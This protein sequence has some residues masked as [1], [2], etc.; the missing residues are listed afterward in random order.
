MKQVYQKTI[1]VRLKFTLL[2]SCLFFVGIQSALPQKTKLQNGFVNS[3][4]INPYYTSPTWKLWD[5]DSSSVT[6]AA[7]IAPGQVGTMSAV[8]S[9]N[10]LYPDDIITPGKFLEYRTTDWSGRKYA[11]FWD[12]VYFSV[13]GNN[14]TPQTPHSFINGGYLSSK[15]NAIWFG[16]GKWLMGYKGNIQNNPGIDQ[17]GVNW[18]SQSTT[19]MGENIAAGNWNWAGSPYGPNSIEKDWYF[20]NCLRAGPAHDSYFEN[21]FYQMYDLYQAIVPCYYNSLGSSGT[22]TNALLKMLVAGGYLPKD[23]KPELKRNGIYTATMLYIWKACL[24][25]DVPYDNELKHRVCYTSVGDYVVAVNTSNRAFHLYYDSLHM[26]AMVNMA[27]NMTVAPPVALLNKISVT[28]GTE[29]Y[30]NKTAALIHQA[31]GETIIIQ[32]STADCYDIAGT[33]LTKRWKLLNGNPGT[34]ITGSGDT[35]TITVPYDPKLP[36]GR[37]TIMLVANNGSYDSNPAFINVYRPDGAVNLRPLISGATDTVVFPGGTVTLNLVGTD[38]EGYPCTFYKRTEDPGIISGNQ[39]IWSNATKTGTKADYQVAILCSDGTTGTNS[40]FVNI[41]VAD[42]IAK[43]SADVISGSTPITVNFSSLGSADSQG[44]PLTY[45]WDFDDGIT[46]SAANP[47]HIYT[48]PGY[49]RAKLTVSSLLGSRS[50]NVIVKADQN[51]WN[52]DIDNGWDSLRLNKTLWTRIN[53]ANGTDTVYNKVLRLNATTNYYGIQTAKSYSPPFY[54]EADVTPYYVIGGDGFRLLGNQFGWNY[55]TD[56]FSYKNLTTSK[57]VDIGQCLGN[58]RVT[59]KVFATDDPYNPGTVRYAG[60]FQSVMG[61]YFFHVDSQTYAPDFIK[62]IKQGFYQDCWRMQV[63]SP[64]NLLSDK[65]VSSNLEEIVGYPNLFN[66]DGGVHFKVMN[67]PA[68]STLDIYTLSG[69]RVNSIQTET[70][71]TAN[72]GLIEWDGRNASGER[73]AAGI[74]LYQVKTSEGFTK[75]GKIGIV[76]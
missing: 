11:G 71:Q 75:G 1:C 48:S 66:P 56:P 10:H 50:A 22:E 64:G 2:S 73:V 72:H 60:Y 47:Q 26:A 13:D 14:T 4:I 9:S 69:E 52:L 16:D 31:V 24:P 68:N 35:Y 40:K 23:L 43:A 44:N 20:K 29:K 49:Y 37:T 7:L 58:E 54:L 39:Y 57:G 59:M 6:D 18:T 76:K 34:T 25:Y 51:P 17:F 36:K 21:D 19:K 33:P 70:M 74:Y 46:S 27:K 41:S 38:P 61:N 62:I 42:V 15:L 55:G 12:D 30:F 28:G 5:T 53:P 63:W 32:V 67:V 65:S 3:S 8:T 45:A